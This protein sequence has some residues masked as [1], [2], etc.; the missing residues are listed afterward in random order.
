M[1]G[2]DLRLD[3]RADEIIYFFLCE[4]AGLCAPTLVIPLSM[5]PLGTPPDALLAEGD[6]LLLS[7]LL[8]SFAEAEAI[9]SLLAPSPAGAFAVESYIDLFCEGLL[10]QAAIAIAS[11]ADE[12]N[13]F[14][15]IDLSDR[16][17][18]TT[19]KRLRWFFKLTI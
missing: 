15:S 19:L 13:F 16:Y 10:P 6:F 12:N 18:K 3:K 5:V 14:M 1:D 2:R 17:Q 9:E 11:T 7:F 4:T 8:L